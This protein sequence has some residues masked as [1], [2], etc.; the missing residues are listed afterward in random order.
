MDAPAPGQRTRRV[1]GDVAAMA[2]GV[3]LR[4]GLALVISIVTARALAPADMGHYAFLVWLAGLLPVALSLGLPTAITRYTAEAVG[5]GRPGGAGALVLRLMRAQVLLSLAAAAVMVGAALLAGV[6]T[7]WTIPL[8][9]AAACVPLLVLH[10]SLTALL[11]GLQRFRGP[12]AL[13]VVQLAVHAGL[14]VAVATLTPGVGSFLAVHLVVNLLSLALL[15]VVAWRAA[16]AVGLWPPASSDGAAAG[17]GVLRYAGGVSVLVVLDAVVWQRSEV[18]ILQTLSTSSEVAFYALAFGLASQVSRLPYQASIVLFPEFPR[19]VG[20][21]R[22]SEMAALHGTATRY[23]VLLGA[24]LVVGLAAVAPVVV[25]VLYGP[26]YAPAGVVLAVLAL[27]TLP[28]CVAGASPAVLHATRREDRLVRQALVSAA[29]DI[30][31]AVALAPVAGALG[32]ALAS[33]VAQGAGSALAIRAALHATGGRLPAG[34][35]VRI[36]AAALLMGVAAALTASLVG[37]AAG[38]AGAVVVGAVVY[39]VALRTLRVLTA[40]DLDRARVLVARLPASA[41]G[42][43]LALA[44]FLCRSPLGESWSPS[45]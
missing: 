4:A 6:P 15:I 33:V 21:G 13:G 28:A 8:V 30:A 42:R 45:R 17:A 41:R 5:A 29:L 20:G 1:G 26:H 44:H 9:L 3:V 39:P 38:V 27:G 11:A 10:G 19:L 34:A 18:A 43:S 35:L 40:E 36:V 12:A 37:G 24:P 31:L 7:W 22:T 14:V 32:A 25:R 16:R 23:L 2:A